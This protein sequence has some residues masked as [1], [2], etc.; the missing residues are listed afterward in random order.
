MAWS[1]R[2]FQTASG[3]CPSAVATLAV[4]LE[5]RQHIAKVG[6]FLVGASCRNDPRGPKRRDGSTPPRIRNTPG[7]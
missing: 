3:Q 4:L 2:T 5:D 1:V 6:A 7:F